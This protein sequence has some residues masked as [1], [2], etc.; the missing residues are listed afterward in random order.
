[1]KQKNTW[2]QIQLAED[3]K[4]RSMCGH[5]GV[6]GGKF[7]KSHKFG[8]NCFGKRPEKNGLKSFQKRRRGKR[9]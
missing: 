9:N 7:E 4:K 3:P 1:M 5:Y 2:K 8:V 6:N